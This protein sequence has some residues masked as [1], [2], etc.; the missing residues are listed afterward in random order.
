M[1]DDELIAE[2]RARRLLII[3][4][5]SSAETGELVEATR[6]LL[7]EY[8]QLDPQDLLESIDAWITRL[9]LAMQNH[10]GD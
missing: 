2:I 5:Y 8:D 1:T 9:R 7:I 3:N 4:I 6:A 10:K